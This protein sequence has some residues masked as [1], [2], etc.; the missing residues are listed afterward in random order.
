[1]EPARLEAFTDG[2]VAIIITIM[3]LEIRVPRGSSLAA[4]RDDVPVLFAYLLSYVNVGIFWNNHHHMLH[5]TERVDGKV[6]WANLALLF[7][8]SLVPFVIRWID[9][10]GFT[11]LPTA[12]YGIVLACSAI[13]YTVLQRQIIAVN[14]RDSR[15]ALALGGDL[16]G[17]A[18]LVLYLLAIPLAFVQPWLAIL[19]YVIVALIW[20]VPDRRIESRVG[21]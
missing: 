6:L 14:G 10:S 7:W 17:K 5:V 11:A 12:A 16:K 13:S 15:L 2:V 1:M 9:E 8:L 18:S 3:V 20:L 4:L 21:K 19:L